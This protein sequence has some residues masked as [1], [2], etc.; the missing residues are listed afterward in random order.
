MGESP[1]KDSGQPP[2]PEEAEVGKPKW[3]YSSLE[4]Q[5][6]STRPM[7]TKKF[8]VKDMPIIIKHPA[9]VAFA[10]LNSHSSFKEQ[11]RDGARL[12]NTYS[13]MKMQ[14][15]QRITKVES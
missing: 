14:H 11:T 1:D 7:S 12:K 4:S 15:R 2:P 5:L 9:V 3:P 8:K 13:V 6:G 10:F